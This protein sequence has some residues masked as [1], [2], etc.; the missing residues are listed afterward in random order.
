MNFRH[1]ARDGCTHLLRVALVRL[2]H[3]PCLLRCIGIAHRHLPAHAVQ[4][5]LHIDGAIVVVI[6][7]AQILDNQRLSVL[8][9]NFVGF[10]QRHAVEE[11]MAAHP[12]DVAILLPVAAEVLIYLGIHSVGNQILVL[13]GIPELQHFLFKLL[14]VHRLQ[15]HARPAGDRLLSLQNHLL[16]LL[17]EAP[18]GLAHHPLEVGYHRIREG[19]RLASL[20]NILRRQVVL[21]HEDGQIA[22]HLGR[23]RHLHRVAQHVIDRL[24]HLLDFLKAIPK[25][26]RFHLRPEVGVLAAG[27]FVAVYVRGGGFQTVVKVFIPQSH[28]RPV[29]R[30]LLHPAQ[31]HSGVPLRAMQRRHHSIQRRLAGQARHRRAGCV[32]HIHTGLGRH[33]QRRHLISGGV[34][35]MQVDWDAN[36]LFQ[37]GNQLFG[38]VGLQ[39]AGHILDCQHVGA[40]LFQFL[41]QIHIVPQSIFILCLVQ[42][43]AGIAHG[44]LQQ[45]SLI[46]HLIHGHF[47]S[48]NPVQ[49]VEHAEY[50][51]SPLCRFFHKCPHQIVRVV[52]VAHQ[53]R[54]AQQ[55]LEGNVGN[56]LP[57]QPQPL[58]R[59][60]MQEP[61][62]HIEG[63]AAPHLQ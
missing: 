52:G 11:H 13:G 55:H 37:R 38:G 14:K 16:Q 62:R 29:V 27:N 56:L 10:A 46:Q 6:A 26:Q 31:V 45:L 57:Q 17:R 18:C 54:A 60:F 51:N 4:F 28:I 36:L 43:V 30:Q 53:I 34:V 21:H 33:Q 24:V 61:I 25:A 5:K 47:H 9:V 19:Q 1:H 63:G 50:I 35:G 42:N 48:W 41:R 8:D 12:G 59:G 58:P 49:R 40:P 22:H 3:L 44:G 15:Q 23:R 2:Y 7:Q 39:Q 32:H 20:D